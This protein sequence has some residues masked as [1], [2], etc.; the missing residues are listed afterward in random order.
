MTG[1]QTCALPIF[2]QTYDKA[3]S[4]K[5]IQED[6][7]RPALVV[8]NMIQT[9]YF[10]AAT[11]MK[12]RRAGTEGTVE[13][14]TDYEEYTFGTDDP[15]LREDWNAMFNTNLANLNVKSEDHRNFIEYEFFKMLVRHYR[16]EGF[17]VEEIKRKDVEKDLK[18]MVDGERFG[19]HSANVTQ[20]WEDQVQSRGDP[21]YWEW[22]VDQ[23]PVEEEGL[24]TGGNAPERYTQYVK[25]KK[26]NPN[27]TP[28]KQRRQEKE[29][30]KTKKSKPKVRSKF[31]K[32]KPKPKEVQ[33]TLPIPKNSQ[34][35]VDQLQKYRVKTKIGR[36]HV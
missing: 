11:A 4:Q 23:T 22:V 19:D 9:L 17:T 33:F 29:P 20:T 27:D 14:K 10:P 18:H 34:E 7:Y 35:L 26:N 16:R 36:A 13:Q 31:K 2:E 25:D 3:F 30:D 15:Q 28:V 12:A 21:S 24:R 1:V 5:G 6:P 8:L 32:K